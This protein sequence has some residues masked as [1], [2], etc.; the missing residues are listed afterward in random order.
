M[1]LRWIPV[2]TLVSTL[3][4]A[5]P[6]PTGGPEVV[7]VFGVALDSATLVIAIAETAVLSATVEP[8]NADDKNVQWESSDESVVNVSSDGEVTGESLGAATVT[9]T[10]ADG[11]FSDSCDVTVMIAG[12]LDPTFGTLGFIVHHGA[13]GGSNADVGND[14]AV[15]ADGKIVVAGFSYN[16]TNNDMTLWRFNSDG[17]FD[18]TFNSVGYVIH[19]SAAGGNGRDEG[20]ALAIDGNGKIVVAGL[21]ERVLFNDTD[22]AV[23]RYNADGTLDTTFNSTGFA[24][25]DKAGGSS[26]SV[27]D[28]AYG[29][30]IDSN[31]KILVTG[32]SSSDTDMEMIIWRFDTDG[33]L[34]TTFNS[35]GYVANDDSGTDRDDCGI[36]ITTDA[37]GRI[38]VAGYYNNVLNGEDMALWRYTS[39]GAPDTSF[40]SDGV[41][42]HHDAAGGNGYDRANALTIDANGKIVVVGSSAATLGTESDMVIWRY[43]TTG[44]PDTSFDSDGFAVYQGNSLA[45]D[46]ARDL[47]IDASGRILVAGSFRVLPGMNTDMIVWRYDSE[48]TL[49]TSF[50]MQ[51]YVEHDN[52]AGGNGYDYA[53]GITIDEKGRILVTGRSAGSTTGTDMVVWRYR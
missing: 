11:G 42:F 47:V 5:C 4:I 10:T 29:V 37:S 12:E 25:H 51:G 26:G 46:L 48:G 40:D 44:S 36:A 43:G 17:T 24:A 22:V 13:A 31:D 21:S 50:N 7:S 1:K 27:S 38:V 34:D 41:V 30:T 9:V 19:N 15:D 32:S 53:E 3:F 2:C 52:A 14:I 35:V 23:W 20:H 49:D 6:P 18:T 8:V 16:G 28:Y 33:T 45:S 39:S